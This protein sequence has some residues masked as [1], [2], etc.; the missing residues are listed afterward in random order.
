[1]ATN[2]YANPSSVGIRGVLLYRLIDILYF[3]K[4]LDVF[5]CLL[6]LR[7]VIDRAGKPMVFLR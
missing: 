7:C 4:A 1:M 5:A 3:A 6:G 2:T